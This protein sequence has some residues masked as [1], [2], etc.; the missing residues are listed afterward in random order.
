[1]I[2]SPNVI[3]THL[4]EYLPQI[5]D[6]F[7]E[8]TVVGGIVVAGSP[9]IL[10]VIKSGHGKSV[11]NTVIFTNSKLDNGI[12]AV[13]QFTEPDGTDVLRFTTNV[14]H[15]LT[16]GYTDNLESG[17]IELRGFTDS[18]FNGFFELYGVPAPNMFE[19]VSSTLPVLNGNELLREP[20]QI[21]LNDTFLVSNIVDVNTYEVELIS[22]PTFDTLPVY[23]LVE[24]D[25]YR[26]SIESSWE[27]VEEIY[28]KEIPTGYWLYLIMENVVMSKD[29]TIESDANATNT[30]QNQLRSRYIG[31]FSLNV[32]IP[33]SAELGGGNA[34]QLAYETIYPVLLAVMTGVKFE[35]F[36]TTFL[37][38]MIG[39]G[40]VK[41][42]RAYYAHNYTFEIVFDS[43]YED[44]F[45]GQFQKT[46]PFERIDISFA[47]KQDGSNI[48]LIEED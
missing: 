19:I 26:M 37:T 24:I 14:N 5:T 40:M 33:T 3:I 39:H 47:D 48:I 43:T 34:V 8:Q 4:K 46:V 30:T 31:Q 21:G 45:I 32:L 12:S 7:T 28:T 10:R 13:S 11:G 1:M 23:N 20:R 6:L 16:E 15:D 41:Y 29:R 25:G 2:Y 22:L 36:D 35:T 44:S 17:Q 42:N 38:T 18:S 27:R 9:Q